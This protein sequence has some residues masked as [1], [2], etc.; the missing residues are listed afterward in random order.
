MKYDQLTPLLERLDQAINSFPKSTDEATV[1]YNT[2]KLVGILREKEIYDVCKVGKEEYE[3]VDKIDIELGGVVKDLLYEKDLEKSLEDYYRLERKIN[4]L[5]TGNLYIYAKQGA[6]SVISLYYYKKQNWEKAIDYTVECIALNDYLIQ[7]GM[8]S[9]NLR[10]FEQNKNISRILFRA[11]RNT[12]AQE[13][14]KRLFEYMLTGK[15]VGLYGG[16]LLHKTYWEK[17]PIVRETYSYEMFCMIAEDMIWFNK[18]NITEYFPSDWF[19]VSDFDV[20]NPNRQVLYNYMYIVNQLK[21]ENYE[22]FIDSLI[23]YF[24]EPISLYYDLLKVSLLLDTIKLVNKSN[25]HLKAHLRIKLVDFIHYQLI[26]SERM[27]A[28]I[29]ATYVDNIALKENAHIKN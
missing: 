18:D 27:N 10:V 22:D 25:F 11:K 12:E 13:L 29:Q 28:M 23:Y 26:A 7:L 24:S 16:T 19:P 21:A 1:H 20:D 3:L 14:L 9:L 4:E 6:L 5:T 2:G 15:S 17:V 8:N